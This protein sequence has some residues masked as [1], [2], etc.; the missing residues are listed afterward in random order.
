MRC[1]S[2]TTCLEAP[3]HSNWGAARR[4]RDELHNKRP[5][6]KRTDNI[7]KAAVESYQESSHHWLQE[8]AEQH[9]HL[10]LH[11]QGTVKRVAES[12]IKCHHVNLLDSMHN[13]PNPSTMLWLKQNNRLSSKQWHVAAHLLLMLLLMGMRNNTVCSGT[14]K[15]CSCS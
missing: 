9:A 7:I 6:K 4:K 3:L 11:T 14:H 8:Q 1:W 13:Q 15:T 2:R 10:L 12:Q 5:A